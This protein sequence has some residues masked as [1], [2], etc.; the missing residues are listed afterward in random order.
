[1]EN[2][3]WNMG[4]IFSAYT[5][6]T[7][8]PEKYHQLLAHTAIHETCAKKLQDLLDAQELESSIPA[9]VKVTFPGKER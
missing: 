1:M 3:R 7:S 5:Q 9:P 6:R 4:R 8:N 2:C